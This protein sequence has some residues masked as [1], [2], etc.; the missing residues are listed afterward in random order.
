[1]PGYWTRHRP[2]KCDTGTGSAGPAA[3]SLST[4]DQRATRG[5]CGSRARK[6]SGAPRGSKTKCKSAKMFRRGPPGGFHGTV[7][8]LEKLF[9]VAGSPTSQA[10][11]YQKRRSGIRHRALR[12]TGVKGYLLADL[13]AVEV[14]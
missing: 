4:G 1:M 6:S 13:H 10:G 11:A 3:I 14:P 12:H 9:W 7:K 8:P 2:E 5:G